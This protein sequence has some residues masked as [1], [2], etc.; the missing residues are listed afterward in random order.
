MNHIPLIS[1]GGLRQRQALTESF[2]GYTLHCLRVESSSATGKG[3]IPLTDAIA[4]MNH[5]GCFASRHNRQI[6]KYLI[7]HYT[8]N[9]ENT[10]IFS[11]MLHTIQSGTAAACIIWKT[12]WVLQY[13]LGWVL[14]TQP[15]P[16]KAN[17]LIS[18]KYNVDIGRHDA[19]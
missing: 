6:A 10:V 18:A 5:A 12:E 2:K 1:W 14:R 19:G 11:Q 8:P 3:I 16:I 4:I 9:G 15:L 17:H 7:L 13:L